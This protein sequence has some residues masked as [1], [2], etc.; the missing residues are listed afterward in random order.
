MTNHIKEQIKD[1]IHTLPL[2]QEYLMKFYK[3][4]LNLNETIR[5][6]VRVCIDILPEDIT[7]QDPNRERKSWTEVWVV[8]NNGVPV[9]LYRRQPNTKF[10]LHRDVYENQYR[11]MSI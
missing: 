5:G 4:I 8:Y 9:T 6:N 10:R 2:G 11:L 7:L 1:R 3:H